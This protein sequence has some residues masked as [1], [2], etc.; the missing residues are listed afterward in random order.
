[1]NLNYDLY[2]AGFLLFVL[3]AV[4]IYALIQN[5]KNYIIV[6][7]LTPVLLAST[8]HTARIVYSLLG[9]PIRGFPEHEIEILWVELADPYIYFTAINLESEDN[10]PDYFKVPYTDAN[11]RT[12]QEIAQAM[13]Q[14]AEQQGK[15]KPKVGESKSEQEEQYEFWRNGAQ[16]P[17]K[18]T[19]P[20]QAEILKEIENSAFVNPFLPMSETQRLQRERDGAVAAMSRESN[21]TTPFIASQ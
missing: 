5:K 13:E 15:F 18:T 21:E 12:M 9:A 8:I 19:G 14:G 1:M 6:F 16:G 2:T 7:I 20:S 10:E 11:R 3:A 4:A 17:I